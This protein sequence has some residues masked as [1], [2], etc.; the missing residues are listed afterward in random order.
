MIKNCSRLLCL[1]CVGILLGAC[2]FAPK[3]E[4]PDQD[5]PDEWR[6]VDL[7]STPLDT[8]WWTRFKD[9]VLTAMI[10]HALVNN[11]DIAQSLARVD[12]AAAQVGTATSALSP[13]FLVPARG[14]PREQ[15]RK[16]QIPFPLIK[17]ACPV[18]PR[19]TRAS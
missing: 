4:R 2:S 14:A 13:T 6:K 15:A 3:Y 16:R 19:S 5:L 11:Q 9:P 8:D 18:R 17:A 10:D 12:S 7:G 1:L